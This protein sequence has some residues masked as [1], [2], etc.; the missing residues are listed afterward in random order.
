MPEWREAACPAG[1]LV[2]IH[3]KSQIYLDSTLGVF[4]FADKAGNVMHKSPPNPSDKSRLIY[5]FHMIEGQGAKYDEKNWYVGD[6][7]CW[8]SS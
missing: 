6:Q 3:G 7:D 2:L 1:T 4:R 8:K 5:T